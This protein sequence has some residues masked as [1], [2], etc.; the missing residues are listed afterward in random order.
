[1]GDYV[2]YR[3]LGGGGFSLVYLAFDADGQPV[4]IKEYLPGGVVKR[5]EQGTVHAVSSDK[6]ASFRYGMKC[7]LKKAVRWPDIRHPNV[8]RV[9]N[10]FRAND[11]VYMVM[12][13]E[14]GNTL[15]RHIVNTRTHA[16]VLYV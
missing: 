11:T 15:Q 8:V 9:I 10:F 2:I 4:A 7:F 14:Q 5:S 16:R 12:N 1:L 3:R 13:Y 6:E